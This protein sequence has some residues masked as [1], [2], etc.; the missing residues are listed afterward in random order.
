MHSIYD[1]LSAESHGMV[2][3]SRRKFHKIS[4]FLKIINFGSAYRQIN[5]RNQTKLSFSRLL[6]FCFQKTIISLWPCF[7]YLKVLKIQKL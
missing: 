6:F 5:A 2:C 4:T 1:T 3:E 7:C